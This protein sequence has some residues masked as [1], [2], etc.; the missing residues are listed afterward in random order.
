MIDGYVYGEGGRYLPAMESTVPMTSRVSLS[1]VT[2]PCL[3]A[4]LAATLAA[5]SAN[6]QVKIASTEFTAALGEL[7]TA[8]RDFRSAYTG[9]IQKTRDEIQNAIVARAVRLRV[10][11][12]SERL[13]ERESEFAARGLISLADTLAQTEEEYR[14]L[15]ELVA[16][17]TLKRDERPEGGVQRVLDAQVAAARTFAER[18][19]PL[20]PAAAEELEKRARELEEKRNLDFLDDAKIDAYVVALLDLGAAADEAGTN[21]RQLDAL[22]RVLQETHSVIHEWIMTDV[23]VSGEQLANLFQKHAGTLG[24]TLGEGGSP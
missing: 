6:P 20:N 8:S 4:L 10:E 2:P 1:L 23:K 17:V 18:L 5:C 12:I 21:L 3:A 19:R 16:S 24:L 13:D 22:V 11:R 7:R 9:E 14:K 15:A